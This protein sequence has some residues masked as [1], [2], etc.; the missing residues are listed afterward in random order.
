MY[1]HNL[2]YNKLYCKFS[3]LI[4]WH[5]WYLYI[6]A[7]C[8]TVEK[9]QV[10]RLS[11]KNH[12]KVLLYYFYNRILAVF[13]KNN[14]IKSL[15]LNFTLEMLSLPSNCWLNPLPTVR[16]GEGAWSNWGRLKGVQRVTMT[17]LWAATTRLYHCSLYQTVALRHCRTFSGNSTL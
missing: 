9:N 6:S 17:T 1:I 11:D 14:H 10:L 5:I 3:I 13:D 4:D 15:A 12:Q 8:Y 7:H 2:H 16:R